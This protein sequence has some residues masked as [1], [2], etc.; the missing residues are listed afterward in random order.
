MAFQPIRSRPEISVQDD[1]KPVYLDWDG[2]TSDY[3]KGKVDVNAAKRLP[4]GS[5]SL[6]LIVQPPVLAKDFLAAQESDNKDMFAGFVSH[7][8][9]PVGELFLTL[10]LGVPE[11]VAERALLA[12]NIAH[13]HLAAQPEQSI[14]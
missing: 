3:Y 7:R 9:M 2:R 12:L 14:A 10:D 6:R 13:D 5:Q 4:S 11:R 8:G 1:I